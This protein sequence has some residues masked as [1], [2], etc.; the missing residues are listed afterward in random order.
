MYQQVQA[1]TV[2]FAFSSLFPVKHESREDSALSQHEALLYFYIRLCQLVCNSGRFEDLVVTVAIFH[3]DSRQYISHV[4]KLYFA[5]HWLGFNGSK[6]II[7]SK[8]DS[9]RL[10][11]RGLQKKKDTCHRSEM[12]QVSLTSNE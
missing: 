7:C 10:V 1:Q 9:T 8:L 5:F 12:H 3:S 11:V 2:V 6:G 4:V